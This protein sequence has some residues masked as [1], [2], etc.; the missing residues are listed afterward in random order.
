MVQNKLY[1]LQ[2][3]A[4]KPGKQKPKS[5]TYTDML[6]NMI[7]LP[8]LNLLPLSQVVPLKAAVQEHT[9]SPCIFSLQVLPLWQGFDV[10][11]PKYKKILILNHN[12]THQNTTNCYLLTLSFTC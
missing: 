8:V 1:I 12:S 4:G 7:K 9:E 10:Q 5:L 2:F 3:V 6:L 11:A